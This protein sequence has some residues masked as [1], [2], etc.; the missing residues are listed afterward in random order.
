MVDTRQLPRFTVWGKKGKGNVNKM[1]KQ[2]KTTGNL[3]S[4]GFGRR[5]W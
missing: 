4:P 5:T 2:V 3:H 1:R